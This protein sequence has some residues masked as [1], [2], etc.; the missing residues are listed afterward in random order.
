MRRIL[1]ALVAFV[2]VGCSN[3]PVYIPAPMSLEAGMD[4]GAGGII[5]EAKS[6]LLLPINTE[7]MEDAMVRAERTA[8]LGVDVPYVKLG[9]I[10]V[11]IEWT[12]K[13]LENLEG[14][15]L[16]ELNGANEFF[17]YDPDLIVIGD[18]DEAPPTPGLDGPI[19]LHIEPN[20]TLSGIFREDQVR[21]ASIDLDQITRANVNPFAANLTI[22]KNS[23]EIIP[24]LPYDPTMP[25][26][27][28]GPDPNATPIPRE[29]F[30]QMIRIDLV[31]TPNTHMVLEYAIRIR[32]IRGIVNE[33]LLEAPM[34]ELAVFT[35]MVYSVG[36]TP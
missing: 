5:A 9:D 25:E 4:D 17:E 27:I 34:A 3:D 20:G 15:V 19:P 11:S 22:N 29:A 18:P 28:P 13:N 26:V 2:A 16:V 21:E 36:V 31:F 32:D 35:P 30:A 8:A 24:Y 14:I 7:T 1:L 10:E 33:R 6:Q 12:V 23:L